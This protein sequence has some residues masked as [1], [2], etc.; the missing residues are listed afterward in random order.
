MPHPHAPNQTK[1]LIGSKNV[2]DHAI[3]LALVEPSLVATGNDPCRVL[4][5]ETV[6]V[7]GAGAVQDLRTDP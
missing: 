2:S 5:R 7:R 3:S 6:P 1:Q 4:V